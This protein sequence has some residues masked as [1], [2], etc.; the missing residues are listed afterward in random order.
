MNKKIVVLNGSPRPSGNTSALIREFVK[1]AEEAG[2]SVTAFSLHDM[3]IKGCMGCWGGGKNPENPCAAKDDMDKIY[4]FYREAD[5]VVLA[6]P[7]Y[8]WMISGQLK[9]AFDRLFAIAEEDGNHQN[10][11]KSGILLMTA[12]GDGFE[13]SV[14]WYERLMNHI[15]WKDLGQV[16]AANVTQPGDIEQKPELE[17]AYELGKAI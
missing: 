5:V 11:N 8:Y 12:G 13:E 17:K 4:P 10:P 7:L 14:Y 3:N 2:N 6:S 1:G 15:K 16:L 9:T